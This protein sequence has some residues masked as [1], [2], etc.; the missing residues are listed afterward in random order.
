MSRPIDYAQ[1]TLLE[2]SPEIV[3]V[4]HH[5]QDILGDMGVIVSVRKKDDLFLSGH[6]LT[7]AESHLARRC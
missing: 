3:A 2:L 4:I 7:D 5:L 1:V 6:A